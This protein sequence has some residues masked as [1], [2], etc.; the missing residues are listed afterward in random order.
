MARSENRSGGQPGRDARRHRRSRLPAGTR[1]AP[2][3]CIQVDVLP[4]SA[5]G[6]NPLPTFF[7]APGRRHEPGGPRDRDGADASSG[8]RANCLK[9]WIVPDKWADEPRPRAEQ[10]H[11]GPRTS[12]FD[13][14]C[15]REQPA[16]PCRI[17]RTTYVPPGSRRT[18]PGSP[19]AGDQG[20]AWSRSSWPRNPDAGDLARVVPTPFASTRR[21]EHGGND[22]RR[23]H[24]GMRASCPRLPIPATAA[25]NESR[26]HDRADVHGVH[27]PSSCDRSA[28]D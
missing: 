23:Q 24:L 20:H 22:Y 21:G 13:A 14:T 19:C 4:Q 26:R 17:R 12:T 6:G 1:D 11:P 15:E 5:R 28:C 10:D 8:E 9:P 7:G 16:A 3:T 18:T 25:R 2:D 27:E